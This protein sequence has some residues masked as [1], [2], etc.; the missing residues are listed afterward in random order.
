MLQLA[1]ARLRAS[2]FSDWF[3]HGRKSRDEKTM[4]LSKI[5]RKSLKLR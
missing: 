3:P 4:T 1:N 2:F 5:H